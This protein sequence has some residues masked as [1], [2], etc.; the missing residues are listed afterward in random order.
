M[1]PFSIDWR[2]VTITAIVFLLVIIG[3]GV[4]AAVIHWPNERDGWPLAVAIA[5]VIA[6]M[7]LMAR[8]FSFLQQSRASFEG[9]LGIK[10]NFSAA[11][12]VA[13]VGTAKLTENLIQ[14]GMVIS[15]SAKELNAAAVK[16]TQ[17]SV[18]VIDLGDGRAWYATRL[19]A[20]AATA[21]FLHAPKALI[22]LG[23]RGGQP[24]RVAGWIRPADIVKSLIRIEP[25]YGEVWQHAQAYLCHLQLIPTQ[26]LEKFPKLLDYQRDAFAEAGSAAIM[27]ILLDQMSS[28]DAPAATAVPSQL[29]NPQAPKWITMQDADCTFDAWLVRETLDLGKPER[30]QL[31]TLLAA[32]AD[33]VV[34]TREGEYAGLIDVVRA[35]REL[36]RQ[37]VT[38]SV[39]G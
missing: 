2:E 31:T 11:A 14:S 21:E 38:P 7:P 13:T 33:L 27:Y 18:V 37:M 39:S 17:E 19:F 29:E 9:P 25:A 6:F 12:Q 35:Q 32:K 34:A 36:L 10:I 24:R 22:L 5:A 30:E 3:F 16:A 26:A 8:T 1:L 20:L 28:L 23:Q 15:S 4:L